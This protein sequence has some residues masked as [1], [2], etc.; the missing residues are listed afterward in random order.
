MIGLQPILKKN[1][2]QKEQQYGQNNLNVVRMGRP[3]GSSNDI[4]ETANSQGS[5]TG[6]RNV[7]SSAAGGNER[8]KS[9]RLRQ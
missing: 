5:K 3:N 2:E 4:L 8:H 7:G 1:K 6:R 9:S